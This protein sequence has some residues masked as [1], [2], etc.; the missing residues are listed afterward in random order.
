MIAALGQSA[1]LSDHHGCIDKIA[2][3]GKVSSNEG[4]DIIV[5]ERNAALLDRVSAGILTGQTGQR[6][7][8]SIA[9]E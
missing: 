5:R 7:A 3:D 8:E 4:N 2:K 1:D 6:P 9:G